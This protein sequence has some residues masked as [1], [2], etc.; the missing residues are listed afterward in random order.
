MV[1]RSRSR[2]LAPVGTP[3]EVVAGCKEYSARLKVSRY[4]FSIFRSSNRTRNCFFPSSLFLKLSSVEL[5]CYVSRW[6]ATSSLELLSVIC[7]MRT[8]WESMDDRTAN[9]QTSVIPRKKP[10]TY[11]KWCFQEGTLVHRSPQSSPNWTILTPRS[12]NFSL[13]TCH[14]NRV[15]LVSFSVPVKQEMAAYF[16]ASASWNRMPQTPLCIQH[17]SNQAILTDTVWWHPIP[18]VRGLP[19]FLPSLSQIAMHDLEQIGSIELYSLSFTNK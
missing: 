11:M 4:N 18:L 6:H 10:P 2:R 15:A 14:L 1:E 3:R 5:S 7:L 9:Y 8:K 17:W 19:K 13:G 16:T 12:C